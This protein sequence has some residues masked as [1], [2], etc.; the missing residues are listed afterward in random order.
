MPDSP[1]D[2]ILN[3]LHALQAELESEIDDLLRE[4]REQFR[5]SLEQG[6]VRFEQ[7]M[8]ALQRRQKTGVW[9][10]LRTARLGHLLTAPLI[11]SVIIP[12]ILLDALVTLYQHV[13]FRVYGIPRV[14]RSDYFSN[15]RHHL[16]YLNVIEKINCVYCSYGNGLIEYVR[17]ISARTEQYWCPIKHAQRTPDPHRLVER[18]VDYGD[19]DAY[20]Q[21][22]Q[23]LRIE[24]TAIQK[25]T[26][27]STQH[28]EGS[29]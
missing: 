1:I 25:T 4:K 13:C 2:D 14:T 16:A 24:I 27:S 10:Y 9:T 26:T 17:E 8:R 11:Y 18:F 12:F 19:A 3:R 21:R 29:R 23:E 28:D 6:K 7:G 22:L 15:D 5:Y 20:K